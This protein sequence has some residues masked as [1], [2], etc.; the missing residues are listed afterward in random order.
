MSVRPHAPTSVGTDTYEWDANGNLTGRTV[1]G[2]AETFTWDV[3]QRLT[4][5][6]GPAAADSSFVYDADGQRLVR[7]EGEL[8]TLYL[9][10]HEVTV[11]VSGMV[12][13]A[14][15]SYS[16][17]GELIATRT[18]S[19]SDYVVTDEQGSVEMSMPGGGGMPASTRA[20]PSRWWWRS[21]AGGCALGALGAGTPTAGMG[22]LPGCIAVEDQSSLQASSTASETTCGRNGNDETP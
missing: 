18:P 19:G 5:I 13:N 1:A 14:V 9:G 3:E 15:R 16:F 12:T 2:K 10:A 21:L 7:K 8:T 11:D 6:D 17:D 22:A 4:G 20:S